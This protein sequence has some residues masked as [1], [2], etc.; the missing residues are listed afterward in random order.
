MLKV[1]KQHKVEEDGT[2]SVRF[3]ATLDKLEGYTEAG[4][5]FANAEVNGELTEVN[6]KKMALNTAYAKLNADG[7]A[8]TPEETGTYDAYSNFFF[9]Y[10]L[11]KIPADVTIYVRAYVVIDG[12]TIYSETV[13]FV[14]NEL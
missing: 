7:V 9:A 6:G 3:I 1:A 13:P 4:F 5:I 10:A 11:R 2:K 12:V 8:Q 14:I